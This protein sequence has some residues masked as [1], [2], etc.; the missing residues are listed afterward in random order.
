MFANRRSLF[1]LLSVLI[2]LTDALFV[3]L[4]YQSDRQTLNQTLADE[5]KALHK[6]YQ[7]ALSMTLTNMQ[8]IATF[9]AGDPRVQTLFEQAVDAV[10]QEGGGPGGP[11]AARL[12]DE[13]YEV[14]A[15]GWQKM[16]AEYQVR[17]LHFHLGPGSTSFLRVHKPEKFGDNMDDLRHMVVDVNRDRQP[18]TGLELGRVYAGLRG[19]VPVFSPASPREPIGALEVGTSYGTLI[20]SLSQSIGA[21][22]A[23]LL[24]EQRVE[25]ATWQRP[26]E[27]LMTDC[28]CFIEATSSSSLIELLS[29][30][31]ESHQPASFEG[32]TYLVEAESGHYAVSE[33]AI[34]DYVGQRDGSADSVGRVVIWWSADDLIAGLEASTWRNVVY[35]LIGFVLIEVVLFG[36]MRLTLRGLEGEVVRRT[37]EIH[38]LND[39]LK[40]IAHHDFLTGVYT[41]RYLI[42]RLQQ[43]CNR[44]SREQT[45]LTLLM[46]DID[47]FKMI[48]DTYGH[49]AGDQ[50]LAD[51]GAQLLD[52]C[53]DYDLVGR[54][55]GEEFCVVLPGLEVAEAF[56]VAEALRLRIQRSLALPDKAGKP[57]TVSIGLAEYDPEQSYQQLI[58]TADQAL[59]RAKEN[60][61]NRSIISEPLVTSG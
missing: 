50:V 55:G 20:D 26:N 36:A 17:Q 54:Y 34:R 28:G 44:A 22:V 31:D 48:N 12:R 2:F 13:L 49:P 8:Q 47:Y 5:G 11:K 59:Y 29:L 19:I 30:E 21:Q 37:R 7:V 18:R 51:M 6:S 56:K 57:V 60:G 58:K 39:R 3:V 53:R 46:L 38:D 45:P 42:E 35:G 40:K 52:N 43:E 33:F 9:V 15:P 25:E 10:E 32:R 4:N 27:S 1:L 16:T 23:V 61:R 41:R 14:V 24:K